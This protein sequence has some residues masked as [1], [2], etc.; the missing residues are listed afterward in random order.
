M[1][2]KHR[3]CSAWSLSTRPPLNHAVP[4]PYKRRLSTHAWYTLSLMDTGVPASR[5]TKCSFLKACSA[6]ATLWR[7]SRS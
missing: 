3:T 1:R 6:W 2:R 7:T 4:M 5:Q